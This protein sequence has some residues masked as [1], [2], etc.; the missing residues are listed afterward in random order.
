MSVRITARGT[1]AFLLVAAFF[2]LLTP[3][4]WE[5]GGESWS[6]WTAARILAETGGFPVFSR[7][8]LYTA[9][10]VPFLQIPFPFSQDLEYCLTHLFAL[11]C[12]FSLS[13]TNL[14]TW[15]SLLLVAVLTPLLGI[16]EGGGTLAGIGFLSLYLKTFVTAK[17]GMWPMLPA[18]LL[19]AALCHSAFWP[20]LWL[21][22]LVTTYYA[23]A[24]RLRRSAVVIDLGSTV[25]RISLALLIAFTVSALLLQSGRFDHNHML[26]DPRFA[27]IPLTSAI[28]IGF[29]QLATWDIVVR[30][31][32]PSVWAAK[33]WYFE[34][35]KFFGNAQ[36]FLDV[37]HNDPGLFFSIVS[38]HIDNALLLPLY[39]YSFLPVF[40][41]ASPAIFLLDAL[42][43]L[44]LLVGLHTIWRERGTGAALI[45]VIGVGAIIAALLLTAFSP[46][47]VITL[48]PVFILI[49]TRYL[50]TSGVGR[51]HAFLDHRW[52]KLGIFL[53]GGTL[54]L[55]NA[56]FAEGNAQIME[57][58]GAAAPPTALTLATAYQKAH[59]YTC[60]QVNRFSFQA[61]AVLDN[62][63]FLRVQKG[64][65]PSAA[66]SS[67][68]R[69]VSPKTKILSAE[70]TFFSAFT[71]VAIDNNL[72]VSS[73]PPYED[74]SQYSKMLLDGVD[75]FFVSE[76]MSK[77]E[78]SISTQLF[79]RYRLHI[80]PYL[81]AN[82]DNFEVI[83]VPRY[84]QAFI[85]KDRSSTN[86]GFNRYR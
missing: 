12:L 73:L 43:F 48:L 5:P 31:Y 17:P 13:R 35:P 25:G 50:G 9:W 58:C 61:R 16:V 44:V 11:V 26:V 70:N 65:S 54:V 82:R 40:W 53:L 2:I 38:R 47:Y 42:I 8:V 32:D 18:T 46:R 15:K 69:L 24:G 14:A 84:G 28:N 85:R 4:G 30:V 78:E 66:H 80:Q 72:Q 55:T 64:M 10:L 57:G 33:D 39:F 56:P 59:R 81:N 52:L 74:Q 62:E 27:P 68:N 3:R 21:H 49:Y 76:S 7:N 19:A 86:F 51:N 29:F 63:G 37:L 20:F 36:H 67:L 77:D 6:A 45:L 83:D 79:L 75:T 23:V 60:R 34:T 71:R 41:L 1:L 22:L